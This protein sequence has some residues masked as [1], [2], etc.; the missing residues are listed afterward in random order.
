MRSNF[1]IATLYL[2][3]LAGNMKHEKKNCIQV[4]MSPT[5]SLKS[6]SL[7]IAEEKFIAVL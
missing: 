7:V 1:C 3:F 6:Q 2:M 4:K 5:L